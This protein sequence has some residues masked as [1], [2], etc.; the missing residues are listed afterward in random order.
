MGGDLEAVLLDAGD[1]GDLLDGRRGESVAD[2]GGDEGGVLVPWAEAVAEDFEDL[3]GVEGAI[4][5]RERGGRRAE[6]LVEFA[7]RSCWRR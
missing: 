1:S 4:F 6:W 5:G 3:G 7:G 2:E